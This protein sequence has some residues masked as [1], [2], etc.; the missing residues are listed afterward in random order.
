MIDLETEMKELGRS[1]QIN[2]NNT[3]SLILTL[4]VYLRHHAGGRSLHGGRTHTHIAGIY[5]VKDINENTRRLCEICSTL[6][7]KT[8]KR[9]Q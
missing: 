3:K 5:L 2:I 6:M 9:R 1:S 8:L 7:I 4:Q